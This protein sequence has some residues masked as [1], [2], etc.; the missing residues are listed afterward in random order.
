MKDIKGALLDDMKAM[1]QDEL[2]QALAGP[3]PPPAPAAA[4]LPVAAIAP[5]VA[6][7]PAANPPVVDAPPANNDNAGGQ[8]LN[9]ARNV[10]AVEMKFEDMENYMVEKAKRESLELV[11]DLESKQMKALNQKMSKMEELMKGQGIGYSFDFDDILCM[12]GD[13]LPEK[14]KMPQLQKFDGTGDPRIHLSQYITTMSTTKAP[15]YVVARLFVLSLEGM[16]VN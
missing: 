7:A 11:Q 1:M 13:E 4:N 5:T 15:M 8:T 10:P 2:R 12:E 6:I 9:A 14:F 3:M 16:A